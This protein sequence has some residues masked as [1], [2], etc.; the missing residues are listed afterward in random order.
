MHGTPT[1]MARLKAETA[2]LHGQA[3]SRPLQKRLAKG[4]I[5]RSL[6]ADYL[7]Q[8]LLVHR[9][10]EQRLESASARHPQIAAVFRNDQRREGNLRDDLAFLGRDA[11]SIVPLAATTA[12]VKTI[13]RTSA[14]APVALLGLLYVLEGSTNGSKF[15]AK[16]LGR[17]FGLSGSGG[18]GL[19]YLDP[20]GDM[21]RERWSEFKALMDAVGFGAAES[22]AIVA[23]ARAMFQ[24][25]ID[26]SDELIEP[27]PALA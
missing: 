16:A 24:G 20:Y 1:I 27:A 22:D 7:A 18:D 13:E 23:G 3:E 8:L 10:L 19:R 17:S 6:Y 12:L 4:E 21:Q 14:A 9:A 26:V 25:I 11:R 5:D 2:A 15:I